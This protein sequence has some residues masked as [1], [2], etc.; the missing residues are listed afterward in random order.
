MRLTAPLPELVTE[1]AIFAAAR[2]TV[3]AEGVNLL[4]WAISGKFQPRRAAIYLQADGTTRTISDAT[5]GSNGVEIW[6][7]RADRG[8]TKRWWLVD[9]L[10]N[11]GADVVLVTPGGVIVNVDLPAGA[12]RLYLAGA[13]SAGS[14]T[15]YAEPEE[16]AL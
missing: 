3:V 11:G 14:P 16:E 8:G 4:P 1:S 12:E 2:P 10:I 15:Y 6:I 7:W 5:A 9:H 13:P